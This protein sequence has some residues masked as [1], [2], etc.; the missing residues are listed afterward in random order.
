MANKKIGKPPARPVNPEVPAGHSVTTAP[1]KEKPQ[2]EQ[3]ERDQAELD[4]LPA[5]VVIKNL[6]VALAKQQEESKAAL[7]IAA[8]AEAARD[9]AGADLAAVAQK[10]RKAEQ[11]AAKLREDLLSLNI[12]VK[13]LRATDKVRRADLARLEG[14]V[15]ALA[16]YKKLAEAASREAKDTEDRKDLRRRLQE[17][18][19]Q[20][21]KA[22]K[23][24]AK[25]LRAFRTADKLS[26][27]ATTAF[28]ELW[29]HF[30]PLFAWLFAREPE[31]RALLVEEWADKRTLHLIDRMV[32][33]TK[34]ATEPAEQ[35][36]PAADP[37]DP[38]DEAVRTVTADA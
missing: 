34:P 9:K 20:L 26:D 27:G 1:A 14:R 24:A 12:E 25:N 23:E 13:S 21:A 19:E 31:I 17:R 16:E 32:A 30:S 6:R 22:E 38:V 18:G 33:S 28:K 3:V 36:K 8:E 4:R 15:V 5:H 29:E 7:K 11:L 10:E 35:Q 37:V 2:Q